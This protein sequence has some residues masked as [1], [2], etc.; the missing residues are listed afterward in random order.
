L[1]HALASAN[2]SNDNWLILTRTSSDFANGR[3]QRLSAPYDFHMTPE[4]ITN[5]TLPWPGA[6]NGS[7]TIIKFRCSSTFFHTVQRGIKGW[8]GF[9]KCLNYL[10]EEL[11]YI[12][13]GIIEK[14]KALV[15]VNSV[16]EKYSKTVEAVR[17][18]WVG[19][20]DPPPGNQRIDLGGGL[21]QIEY[22][23]GQM[24]EAPYVKHY[25]ENQS[26]S[27]VEI[28]INGR[29]MTSNVF[30]DIWQL[31]NH[32]SYN[33]FLAII[34][35]VSQNRD[36]LP[37]TRTSKNGIRS[38]DPKLEKLFEWIRS[39]H[40]SPHKD[41][42][43][44]QSERELVSQLAED[45]SRHIRNE[46]KRVQTEFKI[47]VTLGSPVSVDLYVFDGHDIV[48][49]EAKKD[50]ADI[51]NLYQLLMYWDGAVQDGISPTEGILV[52]R[53]FS[54]GVDIMLNVLNQ[55]NDRSGKPY[56]FSKR[57]WRDEG[58]RYPE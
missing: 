46:A 38:G 1:K 45:K 8:A 31:E 5:S 49:Y 53:E 34:N 32:P 26:T 20:Y 24:K 48:L 25:K 2:P 37:K 17:P 19:Y 12:Y 11:G 7:G 39:T 44:A 57:T 18:S 51:Q 6:F 13:S 27:G 40:P 55:I 54:P 58:I 33:H 29:V 35:L 47:F 50:V 22:T 36:A 15:T 21:L 28:R 52:A 3:Y 30:K 16:G 23:F 10:V 43:N 42:A 41:L 14:G 9:S 56:K 4:M